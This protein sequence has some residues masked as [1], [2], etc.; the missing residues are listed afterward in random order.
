MLCREFK[1]PCQ[2]VPLAPSI[3]APPLINALASRGLMQQPVIKMDKIDPC[4]LLFIDLLSDY[5]LVH[6]VGDAA[7]YWSHSVSAD[8]DAT[9]PTV[10]S[11]QG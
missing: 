4:E 3:K 7:K 1:E 8:Q 10:R 9:V 2:M 11:A 5:V 6:G